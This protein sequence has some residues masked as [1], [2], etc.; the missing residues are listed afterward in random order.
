MNKGRLEV[1][2]QTLLW[3]ALLGLGALL[4]LVSLG[5]PPLGDAEASSAL[6]AATGALASPFWNGGN[7]TWGSASYQT[8][9]G[10]LY[11]VLGTS[12]AAARWVPALAG[13]GLILVSWHLRRRVG[14]ARAIFLGLLLAISSTMLISSRTAGGTSLALLGVGMFLAFALA[15]PEAER[16]IRHFAGMGVGLGLALASGPATWNGL[17]SLGIAVAWLRWRGD[18]VGDVERNMPQGAWRTLG[19]ALLVTFLGLTTQ[20]GAAMDGLGVALQ[21][22]AQWLAGWTQPGSL[23]L[24]TAFALLPVYEPLILVFG[25]VG[26]ARREAD[27]LIWRGARVWA[28]AAAVLFILRAGRR[29][30]DLVWVVLPMAVLATAP[31]GTLIE[32]LADGL[33]DISVYLMAGVLAALAGFTYLQLVGYVNE[34]SI[35]GSPQIITLG[36][37]LTALGFAASLFL[38]YGMTWSWAEA[39]HAAGAVGAVLL[40]VLTLSAGWR[41]A[42]SPQATGGPELWRP[43][44]ASPDIQ[45]LERTL[46]QVSVAKRGEESGLPIRVQAPVPASLAWILRHETA[47]P[48]ATGGSPPGAIL[49]P[50][51]DSQPSLPGAYVG[52]R[53]GVDLAW[54]WEG[55]LPPDG[56]GWWILRKGGTRSIEWV[57][58][59][60]NAAPAQSQGGND[61]VEAPPPS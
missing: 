15:R 36:L 61:G 20:F 28:L 2:N 21:A 17:L 26:A 44:S 45:L 39:F 13:L 60:P 19:L 47:A 18:G 14:Q 27:D 54:G 31:L 29:P 9:T 4:R 33:E 11:Q 42:F 22:P 41:L 5:W 51:S 8:L 49:L 6:S 23:A 43:A 37:V 3:G 59:V 10:W 56:L 24:L 7:G 57:L 12:N 46:E 53:F 34:L 58:Y 52:Q 38:L 25:I 35:G 40:A 1:P 48:A 16:G 32:I 55:P 50:V 30:E